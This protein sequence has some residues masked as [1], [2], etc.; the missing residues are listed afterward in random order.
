MIHRAIFG[1]LERFTGFLIEHFAGAFP[2]W[3]S[4]EQVRVLPIADG[5]NEA[6]RSVAA[7]LQAAGVRVHLDER[8]ETLNYKIRD[9]ETH[10]VP[11][12]AV[13]GQREAEARSVA[14]RAR[15]EGKKQ[16]VLPLDEFVAKLQ[17][18]VRT[19]SLT[20]LV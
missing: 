3:L 14:V 8:S 6:A 5:Q 19:R 20:S 13:V 15:G 16:V 18:E 1:T 10:K 9:A 7:A 17:E 12:M 11:Y 2:L 4:P